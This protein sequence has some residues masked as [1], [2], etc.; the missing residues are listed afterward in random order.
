MGSGGEGRINPPP[1]SP[2]HTHSDKE[3]Y[4][5]YS[6]DFNPFFLFK[7]SSSSWESS[8]KLWRECAV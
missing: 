4:V 6:E 5:M 3:K 2:Q 8:L 1:P 7:S